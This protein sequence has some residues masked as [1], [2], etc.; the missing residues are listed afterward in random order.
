[1]RW[2][3]EAGRGCLYL[4]YLYQCV[5]CEALMVIILLSRTS[6][7]TVHVRFYAPPTGSETELW[8]FP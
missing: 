8:V 7:Y 3:S 1:M 4:Q 2:H 5:I 6:R